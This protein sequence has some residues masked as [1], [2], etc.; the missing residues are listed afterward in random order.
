MFS[1][2]RLFTMLII[3]VIGAVQFSHLLFAE[4]GIPDNCEYTNAP[5]Y[6][7]NIFARYEPQNRRLVLVDWTTGEVVQE[8]GTDLADTFILGWSGDCR[9]LATAIGSV[10]SM[11][12]VVWDTTNNTRIGTVS[13]ARGRSHTVTWGPHNF[14][15]V[16]TRSGAVLW[17][18]PANV[19]MTVTQSFDSYS[20]RN[21][22]RL[23][24]DAENMQVRGNL[25]V[26]G[27]EV[28]DMNT[29]Q[30]TVA[31]N[32]NTAETQHNSYY[33]QKTGEIVIGGKAYTC[34][35]S[36]NY[37]YYSR[38]SSSPT[39][40]ASE[41]RGVYVDYMADIDAVALYVKPVQVSGYT[42]TIQMVEDGLDVRWFQMRGWSETCRYFAASV[43]VIGKDDISDL[44]VWDVIENRRV[45]AFTGAY[46]IQHPISWSETGDALVVET[47]DGAYLWHLPT[48]TP[49]LITS[50]V[51]TSLAGRSSIR[52]FSQV[53]WDVGRGH[54]LAV[55]VG[56]GNAVRAYDIQTGQRVGEYTAPWSPVQFLA[57]PDG[58]RLMLYSGKKEHPVLLVDRISN[59]Q[60]T[61]NPRLE[62]R[63]YG[64]EWL[65][66]PDSRRFIV[67]GSGFLMVWDIDSI[68]ADGSPN[69]TFEG[70][71]Q[72][73][74]SASFLDNET[75]KNGNGTFH[76]NIVTGESQY[77][78]IE[79]QILVSTSAVAGV[80]GYSSISS[81]Y[82][83]SQC[84]QFNADYDSD[85][86]Q[87][88]LRD[89]TSLETV[90]VVE[91]GLNETLG[92]IL[93]SDC[94]Y[95]SAFVHQQS[96]EDLPYDPDPL[97]DNYVFKR[98][99]SIMLWDTTTGERLLTLDNPYRGGWLGG[100]AWSPAVEWALVR[101]S[102][103]TFVFNLST[104]QTNL[105]TFNDQ[106]SALYT[107]FDAYWDFE[108]GQVLVE[109]WSGVY[110]FDLQTGMERYRFTSTPTGGCYYR[111]GCGFSVDRARAMLVV[112]GGESVGVWNIDTLQ[113][114]FVD[115]DPY[116]SVSPTVDD[117]SPDWR[118]LVLA[119]GMVRVWDL[120]ALPEEFRDRD[121]IYNWQGPDE[122]VRG[123]RFIDNVTVELLTSRLV[124]KTYHMN[125]ETG[126]YWL[127]ED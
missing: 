49:L 5:H 126:E 15:M 36:T 96:N 94:R 97:E 60:V 65:F 92:F 43:G 79:T 13:D 62:E 4:D 122:L 105:L 81:Y 16:E 19:Q 78:T 113:S 69:R 82:R 22:T 71:R 75:L 32:T 47:R 37:S 21:F 112:Y 77:V 26:G 56:A 102:Q 20:A 117:V 29:G 2:L 99:G 127:V 119:R 59:Q 98:S 14:L 11:D 42:E 67:Y 80:S 73:S 41:V 58:N 84:T 38:Y 118:Y 3:F 24:W 116:G 53:G 48:N 28:Y 10:E 68:N 103:G 72:I 83:R 70:I 52:S 54:L 7:A 91:S 64:G 30:Q 25:A 9:Y 106:N 34:Q 1:R 17:N 108:R 27:R 95:L 50:E 114:A 18:V 109:G 121:P 115:V 87:L 6:R 110:A 51:E 74:H 44:I 123:I 104:R 35:A 39:N 124:G 55:E 33:N 63:R 90:R 61:L 8:I 76:I 31:A 46:L 111:W 23:R 93:S 85:N 45:G 89:A 107:Y 57:S 12:T 88:V 100:V 120:T 101:T 66:S 125:V 40:N 86:R